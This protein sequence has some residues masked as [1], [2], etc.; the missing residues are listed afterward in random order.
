MIS[1]QFRSAL[2]QVF[3]QHDFPL[4]PAQVDQFV[5]YWRELKLWNS[6]MNLTSIR[7]DREIIVKHF[8]DSLSV[9]QC[10]DIKPGDSVIDIGTGAGFPG[11]PIKIYIPDIKLILVEPSSKKVSFLRFLISQLSRN[12]QSNTSSSWEP[13][14]IVAQRA[15]ECTTNSQH[16]TAY[17]WVLTRYVASLED[18]IV[19]CL[20]LLKPNGTWVAYKSPDVHRELQQATPKL[21][22]LG[23]RDQSIVNS[24]IPKLNRTYVA[25]RQGVC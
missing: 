2:E 13:P 20:P 11:L 21:Q 9:L 8:L 6:R 25:I 23:G 7:T 24:H 22:S 17:D 19:Y 16:I 4:E 10:F 12:C 5:T 15:E 1:S 3:L 14:R 18:S